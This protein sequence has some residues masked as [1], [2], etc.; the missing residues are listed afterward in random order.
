MKEAERKTWEAL[1]KMMKSNEFFISPSEA[2]EVLRVHPQ[3]LR[4]QAQK[5]KGNL[6]FPVTVIGSRVKIP[7]IPFLS[8][9]FGVPAATFTTIDE[10]MEISLYK[11]FKTLSGQSDNR[12]N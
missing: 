10:H 2:A 6:G 12:V 11:D 4:I 1:V 8:Y 7:R 9:V 5:D 3:S